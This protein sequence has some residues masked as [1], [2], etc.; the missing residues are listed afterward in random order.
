MVGNKP[1]SFNFTSPSHKVSDNKRNSYLA[2][3]KQYWFSYNLKGDETCKPLFI[4]APILKIDES[5]K[6]ND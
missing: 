3:T 4:K 1:H 2:R 6:E 5:T